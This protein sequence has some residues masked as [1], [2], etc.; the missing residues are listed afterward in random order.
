M[1]ILAW[2][3]SYFKE[4]PALSDSEKKHPKNNSQYT[5]FSEKATVRTVVDSPRLTAEILLAHTLGINRLDLYLQHDRPLE[6]KELSDFKQLIRRRKSGEPSAYITGK[7]G[8]YE[9]EFTVQEGVLIPRP[10][11]ETLVECALD[12]LRSEAGQHPEKPLKILELGTGSGAIV[13][14]LAKA[15]PRHHYFASDLSLAAL[16]Q[17]VKN[18]ER[19]AKGRVAFF[20]AAWL[21]A[22]KEMAFFD[23]VISNPPYIRSEQIETLAPEIRQFEPRMALDGGADG[24]DCYREILAHAH[25]CMSFGGAL[26]LEIGYDQREAIEGLLRSDGRYGRIRFIQDL[27]GHDRVVFVKK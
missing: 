3:E 19:I 24:L 22:I 26:M 20:G 25:S 23:L 8:F 12:Y 17:A 21:T 2:T 11:T 5:D 10:D 1:R 16:D 18:A 6:Q 27:A 15:L 13:I 14:S 9:D 7:K 4:H